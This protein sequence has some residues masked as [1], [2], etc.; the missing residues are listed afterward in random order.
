MEAFVAVVVGGGL[1]SIRLVVDYY[2][3][4][5]FGPLLNYAFVPF[6]IREIRL[7]FVEQYNDICIINSERYV[8][9]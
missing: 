4:V 7:V 1:I 3:Q 9:Y 2:A 8:A 5:A 6:V